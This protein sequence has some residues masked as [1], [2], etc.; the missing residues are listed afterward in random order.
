MPNPP[1]DGSNDAER[2]TET[3]NEARVKVDCDNRL[4][5]AKKDQKLEAPPE[6][7]STSE[8][9]DQKNRQPKDTA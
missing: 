5:E 4:H 2:R 8:R 7:L 9:C 3:K 6:A 1:R